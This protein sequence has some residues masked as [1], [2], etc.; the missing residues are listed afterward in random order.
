M[1][2]ILFITPF[3]RPS[4]G[5]AETLLD[6]IVEYVRKNNYSVYVVTFQPITINIKGE[7]IEVR[8]NLKIFRYNWIGY[9]IFH[10]LEKYPPVLNFLYL[11]PYLFYKALIFMIRFGSEIDVI[12]CHGLNASFVGMLLKFIFKKRTIMTIVSLYDFRKNSLFTKISKWVLSH[13]DKIITESSVSK[14]EI[15]K[16][17]INKEK[18]VYFTE[19]V[20]L[21]KFKPGNRYKL[22]KKLGLPEKFTIL[23]VGRAIAVKGADILIE[24]AKNFKSNINFVFISTAGPQIKLL[25]DA[26]NVMDNVTFINGVEYKKLPSYYAASDIYII[27]S[28]YSE[29]AARTV[30]ESIAC[31]TPVIGSNVGAIPTLIDNSVG[32]LVKPDAREIE[33]AIK[34]ITKGNLLKTMQE[35]CRKYALKNFSSRNIETIISCY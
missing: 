31:G 15:T 29:N 11:T 14:D 21:N 25:S 8:E 24:T 12:D 23:F 32:I 33:L 19:W 9:N 13:S 18:I 1:K 27:P 22:R 34:K 6:E 26:S 20:D 10:K 16:I 30:V 35:N 3:C 17:G 7:P 5:G 28:R 2:K 4:I